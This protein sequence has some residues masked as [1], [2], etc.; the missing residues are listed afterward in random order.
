MSDTVQL[1]AAAGRSLRAVFLLVLAASVVLAITI[2]ASGLGVLSAISNYLQTFAAALG[3]VV[4]LVLWHAGGRAK[5]YLYAAGAFGIWAAAN[6]AWYA[7]VFLGMQNLVFPSLIDMGFLAFMFLLASAY[8]F[9]FPRSRISPKISLGLLVLIMILPVAIL[10]TKG[11]TAATMMTF[12]YFFFAAALIII[13]LAHSLSAKPL[14]LAGTLAYCIA[15][16]LYPLRE[17][18]LLA[19]AGLSLLGSVAGPLTIASFSL[20]ILGFLPCG[21]ETS[22]E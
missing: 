13:G 3:A 12:L 17:T 16:T 22:G 2:P 19:P 15:F 8:Q 5:Q 18:Q 20:I 1:P 11:I 14:I 4:C 10:I 6:A 7:L 21:C 9:A